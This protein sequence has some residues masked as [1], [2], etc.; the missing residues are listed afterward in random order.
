M[1]YAEWRLPKN[2]FRSFRCSKMHWNIVKWYCQYCNIDSEQLDMSNCSESES[3]LNVLKGHTRAVIS[4]KKLS[5]DH[6][7][8]ASWDETIKLWNSNSG[9]C[10]RTLLGHENSVN[11]VE[12]LSNEKTISGS[13]DK[14][15]KVWDI[16]SD[17]YL[18]TIRGHVKG[19]SF[20]CVLSDERVIVVTKKVKC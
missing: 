3:C 8:S 5:N 10:L 13:N 9:E 17:F 11:C 2:F 6:L 12:L 18:K 1:E 16:N 7:I 19:V 14:S 20:I 15:M 4:I